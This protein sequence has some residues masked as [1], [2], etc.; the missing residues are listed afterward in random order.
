M[1]LGEMRSAALRVESSRDL[2]RAEELRHMLLVS[3]MVCRSALMRTESR[4]AHFREDYPEE[5]NTHWHKS[6]VIR[7]RGDG[8]DLK[9]RAVG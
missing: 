8:M 4:G 9:A 7:R 3:E 2:I 1:S 5:D 6:I